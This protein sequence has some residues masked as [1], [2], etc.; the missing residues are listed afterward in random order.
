MSIRKELFPFEFLNHQLY[1]VIMN[2]EAFVY[3]MALISMSFV[4][5]GLAA[6]MYDRITKE[7]PE[8]DEDMSFRAPNRKL[9]AVMNAPFKYLIQNLKERHFISILPFSLYI[10][11]LVY[12]VLLGITFFQ[13][14]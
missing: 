5:L 12:E 7:I 6:F 14:L 3:F 2:S 4:L 8:E 1:N 10:L 11:N 9:S 13:H